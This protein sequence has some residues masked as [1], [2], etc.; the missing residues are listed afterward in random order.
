MKQSP[1]VNG[2]SEKGL[3]HLGPDLL[4]VESALYLLFVLLGAF[5]RFYSLGAQPLHEK[6]AQLA[7]DAWRFYQGGAANIRGHSPLLFHASV[8][9]YALVEA[10]EFVVRILPAAAGTAM[11]AMPYLLR[12]RVGRAAALAASGLI[13]FSPSFVFFSRQANGEIIMSAASLALVS[14]FFGYAGRGSARQLYLVSAGLGLALLA[15]GA[16][17]VLLVL[18]AAFLLVAMLRPRAP[19]VA[20]RSQLRV[21]LTDTP[22]RDTILRS[23]CLLMTLVVLLSTGLLVN[24]QGIQAIL[25]LFSSWFAQF[26]PAADSPPWHYYASL[27]LAYELPVLVF[28]LA[29]A[30]YLY[31]R[32]VFYLFL[33][34][35]F[36]LSLVVY[37]AMGSK[38]PSGILLVLLPLTL[39]A[40]RAIGNLLDRLREGEQWT[41]ARLV[42]LT[43]I[44]ALLL[45]LLQLAAFGDPT[46]PGDPTAL[47]LVLLS[48]FFLLLLVVTVGLLSQE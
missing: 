27:L 2:T 9:F 34:A 28:G 30:S 19:E 16:T 36:G 42:L 31:R 47:V 6:E 40:A 35:W 12:P 11:I 24:L 32:G 43:S 44:P 17:S 22:G 7:L 48:A 14:G 39:L 41:W 5:V 45:L 1:N 10:R 23:L 37:S 25:D 4:T 21:W 46:N 33:I 8:L 29:G 13:A 3:R 38:P 15:S 20:R 18:M 26:Q